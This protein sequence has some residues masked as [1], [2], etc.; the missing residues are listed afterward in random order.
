MSRPIRVLMVCTGNICR[1]PTAE[2][3]LRRLAEQSGVGHRL[4]V[5]SAGTTNYHVGEPPD[6][7]SQM[8]AARR[9]YDLSGQRARQLQEADFEAFDWLIAM[10]RSHLAEL[11]ADAPPVWRHRIHLLMDFAANPQDGEVPDPYY[12]GAS[13]FDDVLD[14]VEA[15]CQGL[16]ARIANT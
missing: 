16:L 3:V 13:G 15:G 11:H 7:R 2:A 6:R 9:G 12:G 10:D 14:R 5:D 4:E 1:S 8:H